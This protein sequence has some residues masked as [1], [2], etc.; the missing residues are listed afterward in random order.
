MTD[1]ECA[2]ALNPS[3]QT[4]LSMWQ[5]LVPKNCMTPSLSHSASDL[6][7]ERESQG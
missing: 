6:R 1:A 2:A 4:P 3:V 5:P 7:V